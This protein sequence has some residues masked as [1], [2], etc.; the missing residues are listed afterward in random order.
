MASN[1][2][3]TLIRDLRTE[4][5]LS[6]RKL[7]ELAGV[8]RKTLRAIENGTTAGDIE[9]IEKLL[10][11]FGYELEAFARDSIEERMR[12]QQLMEMD[13]QSRS[14]RALSRLLSSTAL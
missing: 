11:F 14:K 13:P 7:A 5:G 12:Q 8:N 10:D 9:L 1:F 3:G 6:Q 2:W 4:R